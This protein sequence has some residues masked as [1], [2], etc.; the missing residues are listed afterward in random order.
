MLK[1]EAIHLLL[2][3]MVLLFGTRLTSRA[4]HLYNATRMALVESRTG[5]WVRQ[6]D[7]GPCDST[8]REMVDCHHICVH[9]QKS[10]SVK[11]ACVCPNMYCCL[12]V[13]VLTL[14]VHAQ[15]I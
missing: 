8:D 1:I 10:S 4:E 13:R 12:L 14:L 9:L 5:G 7:I 6:G 15:Y 11:H 2:Y 3:Y